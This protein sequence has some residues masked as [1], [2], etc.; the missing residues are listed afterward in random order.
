MDQHTSL[1]PDGWTITVG[2]LFTPER[3]KWD[4]DRFEY[5]IWGNNHL[6]QLCIASPT[7]KE[8]SAFHNGDLRVGLYVEA[9]VIFWLFRLDGVMD[10]SDQAL[11]IHMVPEKDRDIPSAPLD[12]HVGLSMVLVDADTGI[13]AA[14]RFV[15]YS[16]H[17][18]NVFYRE[19]KRQLES[20]FDL[21]THKRI[22]A[23]VYRRFPH[24]RK[25]VGAARLIER[26]GVRTL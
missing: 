4:C 9:G 23:D 15:T 2:E 11:S 22:I 24:S 7:Q 12:A 14:I 13:T 1:P 26:A 17:F 6:L 20:P 19:L 5:R 18:A 25:L 10:W 8:I 21:V 16:P 3:T